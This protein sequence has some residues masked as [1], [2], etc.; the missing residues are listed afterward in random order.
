MS[1]VVTAVVASKVTVLVVVTV[2]TFSVTEVILVEMSV[3]IGMNI[4]SVTDIVSCVI[5]EVEMAVTVALTN[6]VV[7]TVSEGIV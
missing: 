6:S 7:V 3:S 2:L 5:R 4:V 1:E